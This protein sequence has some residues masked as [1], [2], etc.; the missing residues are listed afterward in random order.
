MSAE[1]TGNAAMRINNVT[2]V[3]QEE[4]GITPPVLAARPQAL[5]HAEVGL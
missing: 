4:C 3:N 2:K 5:V 1:L